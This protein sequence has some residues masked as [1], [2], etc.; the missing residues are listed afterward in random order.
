[1]L[2]EAHSRQAIVEAIEFAEAQKLTPIITGGTN[3]WKVAQQLK[4]RDI[5]VIVGPVMRAP[6]QSWD[7]SD[8]PYANPGRLYEAGVRFCIRSDNSAN[9]RNAPFEAAMAVAFGLPEDEALKSVTLGAAQVLGID[10][11]V[12][13]LEVGKRANLVILDGSPL[14]ITSQVK[15]VFVAGRPFRPVSRQTRFYNRYRKRLKAKT[16]NPPGR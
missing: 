13:S 5:A 7:P 14:Q 9:S 1:V 8:A 4:T 10:K 15:G 16:P 6:I 11:Q 12:G 2:I 3:A